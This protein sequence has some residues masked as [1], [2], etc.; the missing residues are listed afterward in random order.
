MREK[1]YE[2][3]LN[4]KE[5]EL[6]DMIA[7]EFMFEDE[8]PPSDSEVLRMCLY[9]A[10]VLAYEVPEVWH[11]EILEALRSVGRNPNAVVGFLM[12]RKDPLF[13]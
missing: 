11:C 3:S 13:D 1:K 8:T 12:A 9:F 10:E 7:G 4:K 6:L 5:Q 2:V